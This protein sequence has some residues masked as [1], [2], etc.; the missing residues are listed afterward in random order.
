MK[1]LYHF[2]VSMPFMGFLLLVM[3]F[4]MAIATFV[5]SSWGTDAA[6]AII[7]NAHWFELVFILLGISLVVNFIRYKQYTFKK[8][9]I[10]I[11]HLSFILIVLGAAITRYISFEGMMHIREGQRSNSIVSTDS[12][13]TIEVGDEQIREKVLF[14]ELSYGQISES[15]EIE[16][17]KVKVKSVGFVKNAVRTPVEHPAGSPLVDFVISAG[18]GMQSFSFQEGE[19]IDLGEAVV[20][21]NPAADIRFVQEGDQLYLETDRE[22][23]IRSMAGGEPEP[24]AAGSRIE[25]QPMQLYAFDN[26]MLLVK[27]FYPTALIRV[28]RDPSGNSGEDAVV[29]EISD[30][31]RKNIVNV[32]G[33]SGQEGEPVTYSIGNTPVKLTFGSEPIYLPFELHLKDF[34]LDRYI[35]S[36]S[37][38]SFASEIK[39]T[40]PERG[41]DR[42]VRIFMNNTLKYRGYRF[43]QSSYDQDELGTVLSVNKDFWGT[44]VT[45]LGYFL[46]TLG[47][48]LSLI[49]KNSYFQHLV[50]HLKE[51][52]KL[53]VAAVLAG[54]LLFS[55]Q[56]GATDADLAGI[57]ALEKELV[58]DFSELWVHG[59][60]GRIE[61]MST[62]SNELLRKVARKSTFQGKPADEVVL[63]MNLYPEL[64][65]TVPLIKVEKGVA[66][67]LGIQGKYAA[68][69]DFFDA[70]GQYRML[71]PV[72]KAYGKMPAMRDQLDKELIYVDERVNICFMIFNGDFFTFFPP[73]DPSG[74]WYAAGSKPAGYPQADSLFV[75]RSFQLLKES[76]APESDVAPRQIFATIAGFQDKFGAAILPSAQKKAAEMAYNNFQPF[77]RVF[78]WYLLVGFVLLVILF[79]NIFRLK[80]VSRPVKLIFSGIIL[81]IFL[82]HTA[83]LVLRWYIS[84]HAPWSN[85]YESMVYVA[86][87]A[88]LSGFIFGRK[89]PLVLGTAAFL[90]GITLFVAHLNWMN[91]EITNLVPVLKSYW[92]II[93]VA[94]ITASYGFIGLSAFLGLL[95]LILYALMKKQ[96]QKNVAHFVDQLTTISELSATLGLYML[97][98]GTF[99]GGIWA[100]ESWGRYWGWDPKETWALITVLVYAFVVHMRFIPSL[101]GHFNFNLATVLGFTSV[102]MTYF[103]VNY[104]LSGMHSYGKG[105]VD[106]LHWSVYVSAIAVIGLIFL[107]YSKYKK[108]AVGKINE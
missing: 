17:Q 87:A 52:N 9:T 57:P 94:V 69:V 35:G 32:F 21:F 77:K 15:L 6:K 12:Y 11:F 41:V 39:L 50:R 58:S 86:W 31:Q 75:N 60:D 23:E 19:Q 105:S 78:P 53:K 5:E 104:F 42:D 66:N 108:F 33:R 37:P 62:L 49:N 29:L 71:E 81:L 22:L 16:G 98:I 89:Y 67:L 70:N 10:G 103:G 79:F 1:K 84:G 44:L 100:N 13:F 80:P 90:S 64:W 56:A 47:M 82:V 45:Y 99:L 97:T 102:L 46:M 59:R 24:V 28:T 27:K 38:S 88:M 3:A 106:G 83:G 18:Q 36:E 14:S 8:L 61:P 7:Y 2:L 72:Q 65:R 48:I 43:Y 96:N 91:P 34:Q 73:V 55:G 92:L 95:V 101:R 26:Y 30:G 93:H 76:F 4:S 51:L 40:D 54:L 68:A 85:G 20:G 63:S 74:A 25:V 107:S